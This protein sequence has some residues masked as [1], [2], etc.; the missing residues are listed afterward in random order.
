MRCILL[1]DR[2]VTSVVSGCWGGFFLPFI[3]DYQR[4]DH[5]RDPTAEGKE[6]NDQ[7]RSAPFVDYRQGREEDAQQNPEKTHRDLRLANFDLRL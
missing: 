7:D 4:A 3:V 2:D 6:E 1:T 5:A